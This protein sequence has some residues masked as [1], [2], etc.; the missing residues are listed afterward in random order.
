MRFADAPDRIA[1]Q[2]APALRQGVQV[3]LRMAIAC[4]A[5]RGEALRGALA[6]LS[7]VSAG[8]R[9]GSE[10]RFVNQSDSVSMR[11]V[12]AL[13]ETEWLTPWLWT[14]AVR[15]LGGTSI[16]LLGT[17]DDI[18]GGITQFILSGWPTAEEMIRF[19]EEVLPLIRRAE[20]QTPTAAA[21]SQPPPARSSEVSDP[22]PSRARG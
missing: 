3:G 12:Y 7:D 18:A 14:G 9:A 4:R 2:A 13:A 22:S 21:P 17:P 19:G 8:M 10:R 5:T 15:T 16:C 11:E 20:G 6:T 1:E